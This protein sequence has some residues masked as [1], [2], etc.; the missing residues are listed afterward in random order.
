MVFRD[1]RLLALS[2]EETG[3][4][5]IAAKG[6]PSAPP[7]AIILQFERKAR[8]PE[9]PLICADFVTL[10]R[11]D[12]RI[13]ELAG[14]PRPARLVEGRLRGQACVTCQE[15]LGWIMMPRDGGVAYSG[16]NKCLERFR[17][18]SSEDSYSLHC[19][20]MTML[21]SSIV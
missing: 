8:R 6:A 14:A 19:D 16:L 15:V 5:I 7:R 18:H 1:V 21:W 20:D 4:I 12:Q 2:M 10:I 11:A 3:L 13:A 17:P 9:E